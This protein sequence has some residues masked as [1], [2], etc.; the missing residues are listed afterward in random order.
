MNTT[1]S[2]TEPLDGRRFVHRGNPFC[3]PQGAFFIQKMTKSEYAQER[4]DPR[5]QRK[6]LE[7][8]KRDDFECVDCGSKDKT[9]NVHHAY[10]ISGRKPWQYPKWSFSTLCWECH[11]ERHE[12]S[13]DEDC[14]ESWE[15]YIQWLDNATPDD[16]LLEDSFDEMIRLAMILNAAHELSR[17]KSLHIPSVLESVLKNLQSQLEQ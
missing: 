10:Y 9:L 6:R 5:W 13:R 3:A 7:I 8:M 14:E 11:Q 17:K 16:E 15:T 4:K 2:T 12:P 1:E